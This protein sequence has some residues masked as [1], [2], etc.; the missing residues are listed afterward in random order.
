MNNMDT[1][2]WYEGN[3]GNF[4]IKSTYTL[5]TKERRNYNDYLPWKDL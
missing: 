4:T 5:I 3:E 1:W 2:I